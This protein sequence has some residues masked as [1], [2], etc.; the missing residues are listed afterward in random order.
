MKIEFALHF[1]SRKKVNDKDFRKNIHFWFFAHV[2]LIERRTTTKK[3]WFSPYYINIVF[4][5]VVFINQF[6][7]FCKNSRIFLNNFQFL[8]ENYILWN[9]CTFFKNVT[10]FFSETSSSRPFFFPTVNYSCFLDNAHFQIW[11][12]ISSQ[13]CSNLSGPVTGLLSNKKSQSAVN[14]LISKWLMIW[15]NI[16]P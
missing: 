4:T 6:F 13:F 1:I 15:V 7:Y 9:L 14:H 2:V 5:T 10:Q 16:T 12:Q 8:F 11:S 3:R